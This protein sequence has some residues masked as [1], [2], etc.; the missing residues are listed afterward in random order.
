MVIGTG[1]RLVQD[2]ETLVS[3]AFNQL[4][5]FVRTMQ[6]GLGSKALGDDKRSEEQQEGETDE[7]L[8]V[9]ERF[10]KLS[11]SGRDITKVVKKMR[12]WAE[13]AFEYQSPLCQRQARNR[14]T[15][16]DKTAPCLVGER[17]RIL[18]AGACRR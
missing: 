3:V 2:T 7:T 17:E 6:A 16:N 18:A 12:E 9:T 1:V 4:Q 10:Q 11:D 8:R 13:A 5:L 14:E 15:T